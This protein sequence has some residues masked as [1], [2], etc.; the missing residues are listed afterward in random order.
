[1]PNNEINWCWPTCNNSQGDNYAYNE[2]RNGQNTYN[3]LDLQVLRRIGYSLSQNRPNVFLS[4]LRL[5]SLRLFCYLAENVCDR[6]SFCI[7]LMATTDL[8]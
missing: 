2:D 5:N 1:M 8:L 7:L 6:H 4:Q 3:H